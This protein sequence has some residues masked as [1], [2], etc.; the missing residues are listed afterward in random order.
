MEWAWL[1]TEISIFCSKRDNTNKS[2]TKRAPFSSQNRQHPKVKLW[3]EEANTPD[4]I[5]AVAKP[6]CPRFMCHQHWFGGN[7]STLIEAS[8]RYMNGGGGWVFVSWPALVTPKKSAGS[9]LTL[10]DG[11]RCNIC[12]WFFVQWL[13]LL[14][15][16]IGTDGAEIKGTEKLRLTEI[17]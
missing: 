1:T 7:F 13:F 3:R 5:A 10:S 12:T 2:P 15:D 6:A 16:L 17:L 9:L 4:V 11:S 8:G 14:P